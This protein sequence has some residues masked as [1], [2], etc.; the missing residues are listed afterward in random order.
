MEEPST[1]VAVD[2]EARAYE[3]PRFAVISPDCEITAY[4][5]DTDDPLF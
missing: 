5:P 4:A 3:P 1:V 2:P